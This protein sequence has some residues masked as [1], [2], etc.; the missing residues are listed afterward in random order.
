MSQQL[1]H[2]LRSL[3]AT[4]LI[5]PRDP[6]IH[7]RRGHILVQLGRFDEALAAFAKVSVIDPKL[8]EGPHGVGDV[9]FAQGKWAAAQESYRQA[10]ALDKGHVPTLASLVRGHESRS[11]FQL[12]ERYYASILEAK[13]GDLEWTRR[14]AF[15]LYRLAKFAPAGVLFDQLHRKQQDDTEVAVA[16]GICCAQQGRLVEARMLLEPFSEKHALTAQDETVFARTLCQLEDWNGATPVLQRLKSSDPSSLEARVWLGRCQVELGLHRDAVEE[17]SPIAELATQADPYWLL[18]RAHLALSS[19]ENALRSAERGLQAFG[20]DPRLHL[21]AGKAGLSLGRVTDAVASLERAIRYAPD[22]LEAWLLLADGHIRQGRFDS[23]C[24]DYAQSVLLAPKDAALRLVRARFERDHGTLQRAQE[25]FAHAMEIDPESSEAALGAAQCAYELSDLGAARHWV[26][27]ALGLQPSLAE[28]LELSGTIHLRTQAPHDALAQL[29]EALT[30]LPRSQT[31]LC[32]VAECYRLLEQPSREAEYLERAF[33]VE[34]HS[35]TAKRLGHVAWTLKRYERA[36]EVLEGVVSEVPNDAV[37]QSDLG[38][39]L[40]QLG[41]LAR[42][43]AAMT[44]ACDIDR[45][46]ATN[47]ATLGRLCLGL[48]DAATAIPALEQAL[49]LGATEAEVILALGDAYRRTGLLREASQEYKKLVTAT[50]P[51]VRALA[52]LG[53]VLADLG[54]ADDA[55][56]HLQRLVELRPEDGSA[57]VQLGSQQLVTSSPQPAVESFR[58]AVTLLPDSAAAAKGLTQAAVAIAAHDEATRAARGWLRLEENEQQALSLLATSLEALARFDESRDAW[59]QLLTLQPSSSDVRLKLGLVLMKLSRFDTAAEHLSLALSAG[60]EH[61]VR[62]WDELADCYER[63]GAHDELLETLARA[64]ELDPNTGARW[65]RLGFAEL[66]AGHEPK[67]IAALERAWALTITDQEC[68]DTIAALHRKHADREALAE[69]LEAALA[70]YRRAAEYQPTD[71]SLF[72]IQA[73]LLRRIDQIAEA[74]TALERAAS[75]DGRNVELPLGI[76]EL[77]EQL[78]DIDGALAAFQKAR[79]ISPNNA[80]ALAGLARA[81]SVSGKPS[82]ALGVLQQLTQMDP[83]QPEHRLQFGTLL[84][85]EKR[86]R[87]ALAHLIYAAEALPLNADAQHRLASCHAQLGQDQAAVAAY[88]RALLQ[89]PQ[90]LEW[91]RQLAEALKRLGRHAEVAK[92]LRSLRGTPGWTGADAAE[93]GLAL[94]QTQQDD[95]AIDVLREAVA[96]DPNDDLR[97]TLLTSLWRT[98]RYDEVV[99]CAEAVLSDNPSHRQVLEYAARA[100]LKLGRDEPRAVTLYERVLVLD[101]SNSEAQA[102]IV[103]LRAKRAAESLE[104]SS[105]EAIADLKR[106][107]E[108]RP[109]DGQLLFQLALAYHRGGAAQLALEHA[110]ACLSEDPSHTEAWV[111]RGQLEAAAGQLG[112]ARASFEHGVGLDARSAGA[113]LG[114]ARVLV[115]QKEPALAATHYQ[116]M[117]DLEPTSIAHRE[118]L[119]ELWSELDNSSGMIGGFEKLSALRQLSEQEHR[120]FG[121]LLAGQGRHGDAINEL[122]TA[123]TSLP[124]DKDCLFQLAECLRHVDRESEGIPWLERLVR[125]DDKYPRA[126][127]RLGIALVNSG[128][129]EAALGHLE[130]ALSREAG[131]IEGLSALARAHAALSHTQKELDA[132]LALLQLEPELAAHHRRIGELLTELGREGESF[133]PFTRSLELEPNA[134]LHARLFESLLR[135]ADRAVED[136]QMEPGRQLLRRAS[137]LVS[138]EPERLLDCAQRL[139]RAADLETA[140]EVAQKSRVLGDSLEVE[141]LLGELW[142]ARGKPLEASACFERALQLRIDSLEGLIGLARSQIAE[143]AFSDAEL[144]LQQARHL[145]PREVRVS[146]LLVDVF[147]RTNRLQRAVDAQKNLTLLVP[148]D[149]A[150]LLRLGELFASVGNHR[151]AVGPLENARALAPEHSGVNWELAQVY[152]KTERWS[153]LLELADAALARDSNQTQWLA[154]RARALSALGRIDEAI[155]VLEHLK[156]TSALD[157]GLRELLADLYARRGNRANVD[158]A[159]AV[160]ALSKAIAHG[161]NRIATRRELAE[162]LIQIGNLHEALRWAETCVRDEPNPVHWVFVG[163]IESRLG[164]HDRSVTAFE[165]AVSADPRNLV[166]WEGLGLA[167]E[168]LGRVEFALDAFN[169]ATALVPTVVALEALARIHCRKQDAEAA[170]GAL[171]E[172]GRLRSLTLHERVELAKAYHQLGRLKDRAQAYREALELAPGDVEL[173]I[174]LGQAQ[175]EDGAPEEAV[176]A[177]EQAHAIDPARNDVSTLLA[178]VYGRL[179]RHDEALSFARDQLR[180]GRSLTLL[181]IEADAEQALGHHTEAAT[182]LAEI[183]TLEGHSADALVELGLAQIRSG[184]KERAIAT[185]L[186][187]R[188]LSGNRLGQAELTA[189]MLTVARERVADGNV[190]QALRS[191]EQA[192]PVASDDPETQLEL[193]KLLVRLGF[194]DRAYPVLEAVAVRVQSGVE[195]C[196]LAASISVRKGRWQEA[197]GW[198]ERAN[199]LRLDDYTSLIG[200]GHCRLELGRASEARLPLLTAMEQRPTDNDTVAL[201]LRTLQDEPAIERK[202]SCLESLIRL[203]HNDWSLRAELARLETQAQNYARVVELLS[204]LERAGANDCDTLLLLAT[205]Y[206]AQGRFGDCERVSEAVLKLRPG[207]QGALR[208]LGSTQARLGDAEGAISALEAAFAKSPTPELSRQLYELHRSEAARHEALEDLASARSEYARAVALSPEDET[209]RIKLAQLE[210]RLGLTGEAIA[211]LRAGLTKSVEHL[212]RFV[213]LGQLYL[214]AGRCD[215]SIEA[216]RSARALSPTSS[217]I[218]AELGISLARNGQDDEAM[219]LLVPLA[220]E[221]E[222]A[223]GVREQLASL[224]QRRGNLTAAAE[225]LEKLREHQALSRTQLRDLG[226]IWAK[227]GRNDAAMRLL[228]DLFRTDPSD[229]EVALAY[230]TTCYRLQALREAVEALRAAV[231]VQSQHADTTFLLGEVLLAQGQPAEALSMLERAV[232]LGCRQPEVHE[233]I[234]ASALQLGNRT[235]WI[236]ALR[237][238]TTLQPQVASVHADLAEALAA[239]NSFAEACDAFR[240]A[241]ILDKKVSYLRALA[242][243]CQKVSDQPGRLDALWSICELTPNDARAHLEYGLARYAAGHAQAAAVALGIALQL[244]STIQGAREPFAAASIQ[245]AEERLRDGD[246]RAAAEAYQ[247]ALRVV[248]P[249][250]NV[251]LACADCHVQLREFGPATTL[252]YEA[253]GLAPGHESASLLLASMLEQLGRRAEAVRIYE[254]AHEHNPTSRALARALA[255]QYEQDSQF[256]RAAH[257][258]GR[259]FDLAAVDVEYVLAYMAAL[260]G[261]GNAPDAINLGYA[262]LQRFSDSGVLLQRLGG[263][264]AGQGWHAQ[265]VDLLRRAAGIEP[266]DPTRYYLLVRELL[267]T[268]DEAEADRWLEHGLERF[269]RDRS[270]IGL[271]AALGSRADA[272]KDHR[273]SAHLYQRLINADPHSLAGYQG[274]SNAFVML[275]QH[276]NAT[277]VLEQAVGASPNEPHL[278]FGLGSLYATQGRINDGVRQLEV[279]RGLDGALAS[280]LAQILGST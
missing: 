269:P 75:L 245:L 146:E 278:R 15:N 221:P 50:P 152:S 82:D 59:Q 93:L 197:H 31:I 165:S 171:T 194:E 100:L 252:L 66:T 168:Q 226:L 280:Q 43:R 86:P 237:A 167:Y 13:P 261:C 236:Q 215:L 250:L 26:N 148:T 6:W 160:E 246:A 203:R 265:S 72:Q 204:D 73:R 29:S 150:A 228:A 123:L 193:A 144:T 17:L 20:T 151:L 112:A 56:R 120:R 254:A 147:V 154:W 57:W 4:L 238:R 179:G 262:A 88:E 1:D 76:G 219:V 11:E 104:G 7:T 117:C 84:L 240:R 98:E 115:L 14:A 249:T 52:A 47:Y 158:P 227:A 161:D 277:L 259:A 157:A 216:F 137:Q 162:N 232:S 35:D 181:R 196:N 272:A 134:T 77:S 48:D 214:D 65:R 32:A 247:N 177:L 180:L 251:L 244:D 60:D 222:V 36:V 217:T 220:A 94:A 37:A 89:R 106:A 97:Y 156:A 202:R 188:E 80:T 114:L 268:G 170:L 53:G 241:V 191:I 5:N 184:E 271:L 234:A 70:G 40:E 276:A 127:A 198:Y 211:T 67:A 119:I 169:H 208:L 19:A 212:E 24:A 166:G 51:D 90:E 109:K 38:L 125:L 275:G 225:H 33:A 213:M 239:T 83:N 192:L 205:A 25:C 141:L 71:A 138:N 200:L 133:E 124:S 74:R 266:A 8:P 267:E 279:L 129:Y 103:R 34:K 10:L 149:V 22:L 186:R 101:P 99:Q 173:L 258:L 140:T 248:P 132:L 264:Y 230:G 23:A 182:A 153:D 155:G 108:L 174:G 206:H 145:A 79:Q 159:L 242:D 260:I 87:D 91:K 18:A 62:Y 64:C 207:D 107:L 68:R 195:A 270:L 58:K 257:A 233:L 243:C 78:G 130:L 54:Q 12:A 95:E 42:A 163:T 175:L 263:L 92:A 61:D 122:M 136:G 253:L 45:S 231:H 126:L 105:D 28:A 139:K 235:R 46:S 218:A 55:L 111:L 176:K 189:L 81:L 21:L 116:T 142:L 49:R 273:R 113:V 96:A 187:A 229:Y 121:L 209:S 185:L 118:K 178:T 102:E 256:D 41:E 143:A 274:L 135:H 3:E 164:R 30:F 63:V 201:L 44:R 199:S 69:R 190:E 27:K 2:R 16:L 172:L 223:A 224:E 128:R 183:A 131:D 110:V 39:C 85:Q 9:H 255:S 210:I